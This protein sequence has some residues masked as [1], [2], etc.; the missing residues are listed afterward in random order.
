MFS[1][2]MYTLGRSVLGH[3]RTPC[4]GLLTDQ[5]LICGG[6]WFPHENVCRI[7]V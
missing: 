5:S 1:I 4:V 6:Q 7:H 3:D 2:F